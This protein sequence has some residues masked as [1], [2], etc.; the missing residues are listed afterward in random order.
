VR[1]GGGQFAVD[2]DS[3]LVG[4]VPASGPAGLAAG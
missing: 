1:G 2:F 4:R 3:F